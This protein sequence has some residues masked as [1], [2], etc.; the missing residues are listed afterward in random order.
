MSPAR[1]FRSRTGALAAV[2]YVVFFLASLVVPGLLGQNRGASLVTPYSANSDVANYLAA[3]NH[4]GVPVAAFC[5]AVSGL[6]LLVFSGWAT[7]YLHRL[8]RA[9]HAALA[10]PT[11]TAAAV[12]LLLSASTQWILSMPGIADNVAVYRAVMDLSFVAGAAVQVATTGLLTA[13]VSTGARSAGRLPK[14]LAWLG[15]AVAALSVLSMFSLLFKAASPFLPIGRY[16]GMGWFAA[17]AAL[18]ARKT[19]AAAL[20]LPGV[21]PQSRS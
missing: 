18:L 8:G 11:G 7:G 17:F 3:I 9:A 20:S 14:W 12:F 2:S 5:Q 16:L 15:I 10:R 6:A 21:A 1:E 19:D 4:G 13:A